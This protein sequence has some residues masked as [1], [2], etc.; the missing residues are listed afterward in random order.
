MDSPPP[1]APAPPRPVPTSHR[2]NFDRSFKRYLGILVLVTLSNSS[3]AFLLL[4]AK[5]SGVSDVSIPLLWAFL[6]V[7]KSAS[8]IIGGGLSD[9]FGRRRL[10]VSGWVL[11]AA[12]YLGFALLSTPAGV[13]ALFAVYG[14]YFGL[15]EGAEKA[16]VAD[17]VA[18]ELRGTAYGI[19][20]LATGIAALPASLM[21]G[22]LWQRFGPEAALVTGAGLSL[23]A[24]VLLATA[25]IGGR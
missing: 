14:V 5:Q 9:R 10:I 15:T 22:L 21:M 25:K 17:L 2:P 12:I 4:R 19:Y 6:H 8:S 7:S 11:Y 1:R 13:W 18:A 23:V 20:N 16:L 3:D 24:A